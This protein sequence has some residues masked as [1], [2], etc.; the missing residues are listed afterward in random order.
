[1]KGSG[2][3]SRNRQSQKRDVLASVMK[4]ALGRNLHTY[5]WTHGWVVHPKHDAG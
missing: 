2:L 3:F 1:M 5:S 4:T